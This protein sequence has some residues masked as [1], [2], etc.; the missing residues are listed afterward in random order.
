MAETCALMIFDVLATY[1]RLLFFPCKEE[2][3]EDHGRGGIENT[4]YIVHYIVRTQHHQL[5]SFRCPSF[6]KGSRMSV[7]RF[8]RTEQY[9]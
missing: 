2:P 9:R 7:Q 8:A 4:V 3:L 5:R 1:A 6:S